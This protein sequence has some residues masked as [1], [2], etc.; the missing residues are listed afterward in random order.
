MTTTTATMQK[1]DAEIQHDVLRE[2][3]WDTKVEETDVGVE[4]DDGVVTLT[5]TVSSWGKRQAAVD[6]A[7]RVRGVLDVANDITIRLPGTPGRTDTELAQAV[8]HALEWNVFVPASRIR[9]T[10]ADGVV[11]LEGVVDTWIQRD[12]AEEAVRYLAGVRGLANVIEV[13]P[14]DVEPAKVRKAIEDALDRQAQRDSQRV[15]L[16][17]HDGHVKLLGTVR[18]WA[19]RQAVLGAAKGTPGVRSVEDQL[20]IDPSV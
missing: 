5:G 2:L 7:H 14:P 16:L 12:D 15:S 18:T 19:A 8:R 3:K 10:V 17:I 9:S 6:A 13:Q 11:R 4:V 20:R 1:T